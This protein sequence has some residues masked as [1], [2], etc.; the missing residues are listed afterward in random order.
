MQKALIVDP[1]F[2]GDSGESIR[3]AGNRATINLQIEQALSDSKVRTERDGWGRK[4]K[5]RKKENR[6]KIEREKEACM[7]ETK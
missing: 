7:Y 1:N 4:K 3:S 2:A 6:K 5:K